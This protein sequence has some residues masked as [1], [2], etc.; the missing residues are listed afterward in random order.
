MGHHTAQRTRRSRCAHHGTSYAR[1][2]TRLL[3]GSPRIPFCACPHAH[4][5]IPTKHRGSCPHMACPAWPPLHTTCLPTHATSPSH[6]T[7]PTTHT[8]PHPHYLH[9]LQ[10]PVVWTGC[11]CYPHPYPHLPRTCAAPRR[12][13]WRSAVSSAWDYRVPPRL[14]VWWHCRRD[15]TQ[16]R[17]DAAAGYAWVATAAADIVRAGYRVCYL[18]GPMWVAT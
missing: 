8:Y 18:P 14:R 4:T 17:C 9:A 13:A 16:R 11:L 1:T 3:Y 15:A 5:P 12:A 2:H 10:L 7:P 6:T